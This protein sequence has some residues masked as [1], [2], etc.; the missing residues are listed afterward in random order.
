[1]TEGET[2]VTAG[3]TLY[4]RGQ[5]RLAGVLGGPLAAAW[6][7]RRSAEILNAPDVAQRLQWLGGALTLAIFVIA[8]L[9]PT[10]MPPSP[11]FAVLFF[12][13]VVLF[14]DH[15]L[16]A[17]SD[18][19][20]EAGA[21]KFSWWRA[22]GVGIAGSIV[23]IILGLILLSTIPLKPI[24]TLEYGDNII[25]FEGEATEDDARRLAVILDN[26]GVFNPSAVWELSLVHSKRVNGLMEVHMAFP[27]PVENTEMHG[28]LRQLRDVLQTYYEDKKVE[29]HVENIWGVTTLRIRD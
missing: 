21:A 26:E 28:M 17:K 14:F 18:E 20:F 12:V 23:T 8:S 16:K 11:V 3:M 25:Y 7:A 19:T 4:S 22:A 2:A 15:Y 24:N 29:I 5:M 6:T 9:L 10:D 1:M 13:P 27:E